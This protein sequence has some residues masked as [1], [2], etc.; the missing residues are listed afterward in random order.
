MSTVNQQLEELRA[1]VAK[2]TEAVRGNV[3]KEALLDAMYDRGY[4]EGQR[5][6]RG[7]APRRTARTR[8]DYLRSVSDDAS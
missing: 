6:A 4:L 3:L 1:E 8:P 2:L 5:S 7:A